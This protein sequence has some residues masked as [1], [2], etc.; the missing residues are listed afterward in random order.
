L[1]HYCQS[2]LLETYLR[3]CAGKTASSYQVDTERH[4]QWVFP[5]ELLGFLKRKITFSELLGRNK[6]VCRINMTYSSWYRTM[7]YLLYFTVN[8]S[9]IKRFFKKLES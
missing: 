4:I 2:I 9:L 7:A 6:Q 5:F 3:L 8:I 1:T